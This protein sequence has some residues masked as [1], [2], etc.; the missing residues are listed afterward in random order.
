MLINAGVG[1]SSVQYVEK[2]EYNCDDAVD[3]DEPG[4]AVVCYRAHVLF[5]NSHHF[6]TALLG[7][8][9]NISG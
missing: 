3:A 2:S 6:K 5:H 9:D 4:L 7:A 8:C 1:S